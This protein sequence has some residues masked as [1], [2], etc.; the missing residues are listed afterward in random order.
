[1][2]SSIFV[3]VRMPKLRRPISTLKVPPEP[4]PANFQNPQVIDS[5][6]DK[7]LRPL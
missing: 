4:L 5:K 7:N 2:G 6:I 1:M 3:I